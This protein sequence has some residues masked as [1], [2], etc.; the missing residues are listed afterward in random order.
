MEETIAQASRDLIKRGCLGSLTF[1]IYEDADGKQHVVIHAESYNCS[2]CDFV[3]DWRK[4]YERCLQSWRDI[5]AERKE[6]A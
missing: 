6:Q 4:L 5:Q 2:D 3:E 1:G